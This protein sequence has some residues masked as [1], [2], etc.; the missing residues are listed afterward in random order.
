MRPLR[1]RAWFFCEV[2]RRNLAS[3]D[4]GRFIGVDRLKSSDPGDFLAFLK[5]TSRSVL[6][7]ALSPSRSISLDVADRLRRKG[8]LPADPCIDNRIAEEP[9]I[10]ALVCAYLGAEISEQHD[11]DD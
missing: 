4:N 9:W 11:R 6:R 3:P 1:E 2:S 10:L 8:R 5:P 7:H